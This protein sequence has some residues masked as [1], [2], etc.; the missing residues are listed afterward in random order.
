MLTVQRKFKA[1]LRIV[2]TTIFS[3]FCALL[4]EP[5]KLYWRRKWM[6][7]LNILCIGLT[8]G[9]R[10]AFGPNPQ[11][12][13]GSFSGARTPSQ[14]DKLSRRSL[15]FWKNCVSHTEANM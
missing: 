14:A 9:R 10:T 5:I 2:I 13:G 12:V 1:R 7:N 6:R 15:Q 11:K 3:R 4:M 8:V